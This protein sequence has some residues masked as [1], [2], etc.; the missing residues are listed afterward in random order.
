M[1]RAEAPRS[2]SFGEIYDRGYQHYDGPRLGRLHAF[3]ALTTYSMKRALGARKSWTAKVIPVLAYVAVGLAVVI[4]L[5]IRAFIPDASVVNYWDFFGIVFGILGV[6]VAAIAPEM[7]CND[8]RENVLT[9][10]FSRA[11]TRLDYLFAKL[12]ATALLTLTVTLL[13]M[14][15]Y[16]LGRQ[17]LDDSP[18]PAMKDN[19]GDLWR[20]SALSVLTAFYLGSIGLAVSSFTKRK[21]IAVAMIIVGFLVVSILSGVATEVVSNRDLLPYLA[22]FSPLRMVNEFS[23]GLFDQVIQDDAYGEP[24]PAWGYGAAMLAT[25]AIC[26]GVMYWRYVPSD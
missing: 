25:V 20:V 1:Q 9:L 19:I 6:F 8:R 23:Y 24:L 22:L 17:L 4:P 11:I 13:P 7:L 15:I 12:L 16:W 2:P 21:S 18:L 10:Y 26:C 5:G 14:A 3:R